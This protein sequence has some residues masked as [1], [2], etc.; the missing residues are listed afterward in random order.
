MILRTIKTNLLAK[1]EL[2]RMLAVAEAIKMPILLLGEPGVGKT[3]ALLDY[4]SAMFDHDKVQVRAKS[5]IIETDEGTRTSQI[6]GRVD[7]KKLL[8]DKEY[9][10]DAPIADAEYIL[11]NEVDKGSSGIRNTLLSVMREKALFY[12]GEIKKCHWK[13]FAASCNEIP[14]DEKD[15][16]FWDRFV[17]V[18]KVERI[19]A[20]KIN[21][22]WRG[23]YDQKGKSLLKINV[24]Q[25]Q[26]FAS[27]KVNEGLLNK[28]VEIIYENVSDRTLAHIPKLVKGIKLVFKCP[29]AQAIMKAATMVCPD[30]I[31]EVSN[32]LEH[33]TVLEFNSLY[34]DLECMDEDTDPEVLLES[35]KELEAKEAAVQMSNEVDNETKEIT[36]T[37]L[38]TIMQN[39]TIGKALLSIKEANEEI[40]KEIEERNETI[41]TIKNLDCG[42]DPE[43]TRDAYEK[44]QLDE[45]EENTDLDF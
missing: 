5:F 38:K 31:T 25:V 42:E 44:Q 2:F 4:A 23:L 15:S 14:E 7:M 20:D 39:E 9:V 29:D 33:P 45:S 3:Q 12:G 41:E 19:G 36:S 24:P 21:D 26:D 16:P 27:C 6:S 22:M 30:C 43:E 28:F 13:L 40:E 34:K 11:I 8:E 37:W 10:I 1:D 32:S 17:A 35:V 18:H